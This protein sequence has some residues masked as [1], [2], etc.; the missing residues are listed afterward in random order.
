MALISSLSIHN[1][2]FCLNL[3]LCLT[4]RTC[5]VV[6]IWFLIGSW[7]LVIGVVDVLFY[8]EALAILPQLVLLQRSSNIDNWELHF[9]PWVCHL[10]LVMLHYLLLFYWSFYLALL[11][12]PFY[13]HLV[14]RHPLFPYK[15]SSV[16]WVWCL[17]SSDVFLCTFFAM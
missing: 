10:I 16:N 9:S 1:L 6:W 13:K 3:L 8:L 14:Y 4:K 11:W 17:S 12:L 15:I 2:L 5:F 7:P